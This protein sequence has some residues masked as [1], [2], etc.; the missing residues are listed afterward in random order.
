MSRTTN[1]HEA[2][3]IADHLQNAKTTKNILQGKRE[4]AKKESDLRHAQ[5]IDTVAI[6]DYFRNLEVA[7]IEE[8]NNKMFAIKNAATLTDSENI[9]EGKEFGM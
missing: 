3:K 1:K 2:H 4:R 8:E 7:M 5:P 9:A 6:V